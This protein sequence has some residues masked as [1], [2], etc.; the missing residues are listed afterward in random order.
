M[1]CLDHIDMA[2][3]AGAVAVAASAAFFFAFLGIERAPL[4]PPAPSHSAAF[5]QEELAKT[6][7]KAAITPALVAEERERTQA[8]LG[9]AIVRLGRA[10]A[11]EAAFIPGVA[12]NAAAS[13]QGRREFL[14][15]VF[16]LPVDWQGTEFAERERHAEARAQEELGRTIVAGSQTLSKEIGTAEA[17]Y[18]RA[19]LAATRALERNAIEPTASQATIV[20]AAKAMAGLAAR[21]VPASAPEITR[22]P[23]WGFGSVGDGAFISILVLGAGAF[24]TL[25]AGVGMTE[26][27]LSTHTME[28]HCDEHGADVVVEM[29]VSD[30]TPY[31]VAHCSA[32]DG[33]PVTCDKRCLKWPVAHA[34]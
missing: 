30:D 3:M 2:V 19:L 20:A 22:D 9:R 10:Q 34:A 13:A 4:V 24:L 28:A 32:F 17:E 25:A 8:A 27:R 23:G 21:T 5:L 31:E 11:G 1:K 7:N 18:G 33:G 16:K 26:S 29:L 14:E 12:R 6:I 15:G